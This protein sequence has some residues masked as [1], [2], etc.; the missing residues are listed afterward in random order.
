M[1]MCGSACF[2]EWL[3]KTSVGGRRSSQVLSERLLGAQISSDAAVKTLRLEHDSPDFADDTRSGQ[4]RDIA[5]NAVPSA[6]DGGVFSKGSTWH[7]SDITHNVFI[8]LAPMSIS[9]TVSTKVELTIPGCGFKDSSTTRPG[10][11]CGIQIRLSSCSSTVGRGVLRGSRS[12][13]QLDDRADA[14]R[15]MCDLRA[16]RHVYRSSD[17]RC[18]QTFLDE[19]CPVRHIAL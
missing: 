2:A 10:I 17:I 4:C 16:L 5:L 14:G 9:L 12:N 11:S 1:R 8:I 18:P 3:F 13:C 6:I 15:C 19:R 7:R